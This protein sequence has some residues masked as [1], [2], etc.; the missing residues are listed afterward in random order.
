[1]IS[2]ELLK[3][4]QQTRYVVHMPNIVIRIG[5]LSFELDRLLEKTCSSSW[6]FITAH[7]PFSKELSDDENNKRHIE[8]R[9]AVSTFT[10]YEG[11]GIGEDKIW[12]SEKSLLVL[13]ISKESAFKIG[14]QFDQNAIVFGTI[15]TPPELILL[16]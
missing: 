4:Y 13:G 11:E 1:M 15:G 7:N 12:K 10:C 6:A 14:N 9:N 5:Q 3:A 8:L 16:R 2:T